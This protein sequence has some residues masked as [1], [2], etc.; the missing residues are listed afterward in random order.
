[1]TMR[2]GLCLGLVLTLATP[3]T[4]KVGKQSIPTEGRA[5]RCYTF[6]PEGAGPET[7]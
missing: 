2:T 1:M 6:V 5:R 4:Q 7:P 3:L